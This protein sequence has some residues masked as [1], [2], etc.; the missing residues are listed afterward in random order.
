MF[1]DKNDKDEKLFAAA[2]I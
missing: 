1:P 2:I